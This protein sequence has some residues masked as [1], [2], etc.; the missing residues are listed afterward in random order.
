M[1]KIDPHVKL[2]EAAV[3]G[4]NKAKELNLTLTSSYRSSE[5]DK[6]VGG[7]GHGDHTK[8]LAFDFAGSY[9]NMDKFAKWAKASKM[10]R[11]VGWQVA[12]HYNHVHISWYA[13]DKVIA[14]P[15]TMQEGSKGENV[16][17]LQKIL[18]IFT[19]GMFGP[20]TEA[21][22]KTFQKDNGLRVDGI[23]GTNTWK[24]LTG[25]TGLFFYK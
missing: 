19:D 8:G 10:Y 11:W 16:S 22:V 13:E 6:E 18:G 2:T 4:Y 5:H 21:A 24:S 3:K 25:G 9:S 15:P 12:G 17:I 23:V 20:K 14:N 7:T 1:E